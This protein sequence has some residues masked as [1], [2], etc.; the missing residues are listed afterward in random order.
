MEL[1]QKITENENFAAALLARAGVYISHN[2][3]M[4]SKADQM[5]AG[6]RTQKE[7]YQKVIELC[8]SSHSSLSEYLSVMAYS[9]LGEGYE[10]GVI[11]CAK[12]FLNT[13]SNWD[14][15]NEEILIQDGIRKRRADLR[16]GEVLMAMAT[17]E[18]QK[19]CYVSALMHQKQAYALMPYS[20]EAA[21]RLSQILR[22]EAGADAAVKFLQDQR[23]SVFYP[24]FLYVNE[25]GKQK[26]N[27][28]FSRGIESELEKL[29]K[30][31]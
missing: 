8:S 3:L 12:E 14:V 29:K 17:A 15:G 11:R 9:M 21:V 13:P 4:D 28:N 2:P 16:R 26:H 10:D 27:D 25:E 22:H 1:H 6:F 18:S 20:A 30:E 24:P 7:I 5:I 19:S 31:S 23:Q